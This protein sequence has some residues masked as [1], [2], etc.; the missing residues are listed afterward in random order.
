MHICVQ[1]IP[2]GYSDLFFN[3][4]QTEIKLI[5]HDMKTRLSCELYLS[6]SDLK[7]MYVGKGWYEYIKSRDLKKGDTVLVVL[8]LDNPHNIHVA[9]VDRLIRNV[10]TA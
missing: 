9:V 3:R 1:V 7:Q 2:G 10:P 4:N 5:D 6:K 8:M